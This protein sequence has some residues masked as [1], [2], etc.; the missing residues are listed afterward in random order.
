MADVGISIIIASTLQDPLAFLHFSSPLCC[1]NA[2]RPPHLVS[3][4]SAKSRTT[5]KAQE[6]IFFFQT[7]HEC[8]EIKKCVWGPEDH[9]D[10]VLYVRPNT[11]LKLTVSHVSY[12]CSESL[13]ILL[14]DYKTS[15]QGATCH[16][17]DQIDHQ[18]MDRSWIGKIHQQLT[19][20]HMS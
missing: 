7:A 12:I 10:H 11:H 8:P 18:V 20:S 6:R 5:K 9:K 3:L 14:Y 13:V 19:M 17:F 15:S 2:L 16:I 4:F 1:R